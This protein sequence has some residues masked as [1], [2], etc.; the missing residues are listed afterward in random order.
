MTTAT[1]WV[2]LAFL[3][4]GP[5][6]PPAMVIERFP[7]QAACESRLTIFPDTARV[8]FVCLPSRQVSAGPRAAITGIRG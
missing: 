4:P 7:T 6:R 2:L 8:R 3:A 5:G 1:I